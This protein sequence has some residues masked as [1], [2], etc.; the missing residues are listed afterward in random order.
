MTEKYFIKGLPGDTA[1]D[2]LSL[3]CKI[4]DKEPKYKGLLYESNKLSSTTDHMLYKDY[5]T[6]ARIAKYYIGTWSPFVN[7]VKRPIYYMR[8]VNVNSRIEYLLFGFFFDV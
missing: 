5:E 1:F 2:A 4:I 3:L 7:Q 8:Y 6:A